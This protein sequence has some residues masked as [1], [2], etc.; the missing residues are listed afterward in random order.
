MSLTF[1]RWDKRNY[2]FD[3]LAEEDVISQLIEA[4]RNGVVVRID[5]IEYWVDDIDD[6]LL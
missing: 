4:L 6:P 3:T 2:E 1:T 5:A